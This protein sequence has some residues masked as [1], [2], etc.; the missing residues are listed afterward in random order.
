MN[1]KKEKQLKDLY[2]QAMAAKD[3]H[4]MDEAIALLT[5]AADGGY[6]QAMLTLGSIYHWGMEVDPD[7]DKAIYWLKKDADLGSEAACINLGHTYCDKEDNDENNRLAWTY[8]EKAA[9]IDKRNAFFLGRMIFEE[10]FGNYEDEQ[11]KMSEAAKYFIVSLV[12]GYALSG[13]YLWKIESKLGQT[14]KAE[15]YYRSGEKKFRRPA[16]Y[17]N[18]ACTLCEWGEPNK[19]LPYIEK[20]VSL[21]GEDVKPTQLNNYAECLYDLEREDEALQMFKKCIELCKQKDERRLLNNIMEDMK[22]K[23][24]DNFQVESAHGETSHR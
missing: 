16:D 18:W 15:E 22:R 6:Q 8:Y 21:M 3:L 20:C 19:A 1:K 12:N 9:D 13:L 24:G 7:D 10:R 23:F 11:Q 17:Y 14:D 5:Q 2:E 4:H